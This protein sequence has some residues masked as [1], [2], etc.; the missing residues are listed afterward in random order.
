MGVHEHRWTCSAEAGNPSRH[1]IN[2]VYLV[3]PTNP[4]FTI[5]LDEQHTATKFVEQIEET[6]HRYVQEYFRA[7]N[8]PGDNR[9]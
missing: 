3:E 2:I 6:S 4:E 1:T 7:H 8:L 9:S 5:E